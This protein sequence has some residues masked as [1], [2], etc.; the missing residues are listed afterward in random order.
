MNMLIPIEDKQIVSCS[1]DPSTGTLQALG[2]SGGVVS[3][4]AITEEQ[5][6]TFLDAPNK[7]DMFIQMSR[8]QSGA[9]PNALS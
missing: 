5:L 2:H 9:E 3:N 6:Q 8:Q 1:Y 7:Y 4:V